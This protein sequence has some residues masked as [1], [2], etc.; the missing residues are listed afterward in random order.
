MLLK[1]AAE[2]WVNREFDKLGMPYSF[3]GREESQGTKRRM[4]TAAGETIVEVDSVKELKRLLPS[5]ILG[6]KSKY[7]LLMNTP[8]IYSL[9]ELW[10]GNRN[11]VQPHY[12]T[13]LELFSEQPGDKKK[14]RIVV[15]DSTL[16]TDMNK[17]GEYYLD[18]MYFFRLVTYIAFPS[19]WQCA[20]W[21][22]TGIV[23]CLVIIVVCLL[24][25]ILLI[26]YH[27]LYHRKVRESTKPC[28]CGNTVL[29]IDKDKYQI[30]DIV[31]D[32]IGRT[33]TFGGKKVINC[34]LQPYKLLCAFIHAENHFLS[35][36]RIIEICGWTSGEDGIGDR[37][38]MAISSL[39]KL[40]DSKNS[41][42]NLESGKN[43]KEEMGFYLV[44]K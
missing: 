9:N 36:D 12:Y 28:V 7:L 5:R 19:V 38:R 29:C 32:E 8:S 10:Q 40:L 27:I 24:A 1:D 2:F 18:D 17:L 42:V 21:S 44:I 22:E 37:R 4:V 14:E 31:F 35:N 26:L 20:D 43:E 3:G 34:P 25:I 41:H 15:G 11:N 16:L 39:R 30:C 23:V 13:A 33:L 6:L